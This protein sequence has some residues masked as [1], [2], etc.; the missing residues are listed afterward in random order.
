MTFAQ[1]LAARVNALTYD[2]LPADA[3]H[4]AKAGITD[5]IGVAL[6]GCQEA[7]AKIPMKVLGSA[8]QSGQS[9]V[10]GSALRISALDAALL[11]G[12]AAHALDFDDC[13]NTMGGHPSTVLV[14]GALAL[15]DDIGVSGR[16]FI[17]AYVAGFEAQA[18]LSRVVHWH[19]YEKGWHPT[20]TLG[21]FGATVACGRLLKLS[22]EQMTTALALAVSEAAG[23]KANF[24]SMTKPLHAGLTAR[25]GLFA[26]LMAKEGFTAN[27]EAFE[28]KQGYFE[29]F[30]GTGTYDPAKAFDSW[31]ERLDI[32]HPAICIKQHPCCASTHSCID[33][34]SV[35]HESL[36]EQLGDIEK[37]ET[38]THKFRLAHNDKPD[39][40]SELDAKF[41]VQYCT[42]RALQDGYVA[43]EH[44]E[45]AAYDETAV[46]ALMAKTTSVL[47][48]ADDE[49][50][51]IVRVTLKD[52][53]V[54]EEQASVPSGRGPD[55][56]MTDEQFKSKFASCAKRTLPL[57]AI[58]PLFGALDGL[59]N[60][61]SV[62]EITALLEKPLLN[63]KGAAKA[64]E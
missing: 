53:S 44:F 42:A 38:N 27:A 23:V 41:S 24:G 61:K 22:D 16:D 34:A 26:A 9:L 18:A 7:T 13:S 54:Y 15:G 47:L 1:E 60:L 35:L 6:A 20:A 58:D 52:G 37:I 51:G 17:E 32:V 49:F 39:P 56:P 33:A 55:N 48:D 57:D 10:W 36:K 29:V 40:K 8:P 12:T 62:A 50:L 25:N 30:N 46:R 11:N 19:H 45:N 59:E 31:G 5:C 43:L 21:V 28:H 4:W 3:I 63:V 14:P 64:A 2:A